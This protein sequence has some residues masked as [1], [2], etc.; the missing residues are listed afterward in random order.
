MIIAVGWKNAVCQIKPG[1]EE[2][3]KQKLQFRFCFRARE[4]D[5]LASVLAS[6]AE[7]KIQFQKRGQ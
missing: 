7:K 6:I 4:I 2:A 3:S 1:A 5:E